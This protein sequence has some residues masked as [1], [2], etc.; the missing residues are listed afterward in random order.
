MARKLGSYTTGATKKYKGKRTNTFKDVGNTLDD[1]LQQVKAIS[2]EALNEA[3]RMTMS[4][5]V[6]ATPVGTETEG[7]AHTRDSWIGEFKYN[8]VKFVYNIAVNEDGVPIL[9]L[10][11][12]SSKGKPFARRTFQECSEDIAEIINKELNKVNI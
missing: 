8:G 12:F 4:K 10:L 5:L 1:F 3:T 11:E 2:N 6:A 7:R 9:N